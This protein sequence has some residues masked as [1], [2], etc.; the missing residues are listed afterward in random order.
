MVGPLAVTVSFADPEFRDVRVE[1]V[2]QVHDATH[3]LR[4]ELDSEV[5]RGDAKVGGALDGVAVQ[6]WSASRW[7]WILSPMTRFPSTLNPKCSRRES[8]AMFATERLAPNVARDASLPALEVV[9][10]STC[11]ASVGQAPS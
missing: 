11:S 3:E 9:R 7:T 6:T 5:W 10:D 4:W 2:L 1:M 8:L